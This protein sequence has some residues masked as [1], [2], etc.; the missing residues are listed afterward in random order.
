MKYISKYPADTETIA[1]TPTSQ[2]LASRC[3]V[4]CLMAMIE[5]WGFAGPALAQPP[6][7]IKTYGQHLNGNI[8][9]YQQVTNTGSRDVVTVSIGYDTDCVGSSL[10]CTK[11]DG[12][13]TAL[14][15][16]TDTLDL[17]IKPGSV[18]G[19]SGWRAEI[20][21]IQDNGRY[22]KWRSPPYPQPAIQPGQTLTF[23]STVPE[24]DE[25]YLTGN[26]SAHFVPTNETKIWAYNGV[27]EKLDTT[28]PTLSVSVTPNVLWPPN[29]KPVPIAVAITAKDDYD[30]Q[31]EIKLESITANE[32]LE[33]S[34][35]VDATLGTD[36]RVFSLVAKREGGNKA[37]RIYTITYSATDASGNKATASTIVT[38]PHDKR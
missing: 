32:T 11:A 34:D 28:P 29:N 26:F 9:Y 31:P 30:P 8:V 4:C 38:V 18:S 15:V 5:A 20:I 21:Q 3:A 14:P 1:M 24:P 16:G 25:V 12:W 35:I 13:L 36:D 17:D 19:P 22:L 23:S 33:A 27:M 37:G 7:A 2:T 10:P 6:V